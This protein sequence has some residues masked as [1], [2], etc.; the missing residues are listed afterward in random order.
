MMGRAHLRRMVSN[1][2]VQI[3]AVCDVDEWRL[4]D[5]KAQVE[6][7]YAAETKRGT[8]KGCTAYT[9]FREL[10]ARPDIDAVLIATGDRWHA[11]MS[12]MAAKAGK[13]IYCEKPISLTIH[14]SRAMI[15]T[16]RRYDRVFQGG[17][18]QRSVRDFATA[19]NSFTAVG[20]AR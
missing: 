18:Q 17:Y 11:V 7:A 4:N 3:L 2:D 19:V 13:D 9:D 8:Y 20:S 5:A 16:V 6:T 10:L 15:D 1:P 12:V 14:E